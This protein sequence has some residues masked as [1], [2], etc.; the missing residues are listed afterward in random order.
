[1]IG[2]FYRIFVISF[3]LLFAGCHILAPNTTCHRCSYYSFDGIAVHL[4]DYNIMAKKQVSENE[5]LGR[6]T[7]YLQKDKTYTIYFKQCEPPVYTIKCQIFDIQEN[8]GK[9]LMVLAGFTCNKQTEAY[10]TFRISE[11]KEYEI[12]VLANKKVDVRINLGLA[13]EIR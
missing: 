8:T 3:L 1:M 9:D 4:A 2:H 6:K 10:T 7:I 13:N 12:Q 11:T 5:F